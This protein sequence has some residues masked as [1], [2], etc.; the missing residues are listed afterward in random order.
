MSSK[1]SAYVS[2]RQHTSADGGHVEQA[3][4]ASS[5]HT[6]AYVSIRQRMEGMSSKH[7]EQAAAANH[8]FCQSKDVYKSD[9]LGGAFVRVDASMQS[10]VY[11][12]PNTHYFALT[13]TGRCA[14][15]RD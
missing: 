4:R 5:Q 7:V 8:S 9:A 13:H 11:R 3:C 1:Q 10:N 15:T 12:G 14:R 2:I 6:S